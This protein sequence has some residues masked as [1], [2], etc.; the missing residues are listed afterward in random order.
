MEHLPQVKRIVLR[1][2]GHLPSSI[3][4]EDLIHAGVVGLI[5]AADRYDPARNNS[6]MTYAGL[7]IRGAILSEL[8]ARDFL[9]RSARRRLREVENIYQKLD[10]HNR[11][12]AVA[13]ARAL[14]ILSEN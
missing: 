14:R 3:D 9:S 2:A 7:R 10:V 1:M 13:K 11:R 5:Q 8:R 6:F 4:T 12:E